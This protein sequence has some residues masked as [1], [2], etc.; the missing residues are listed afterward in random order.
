MAGLISAHLNE[1]SIECQARFAIAS[2]IL[3]LS[4]ENTINP[5]FSKE[6][7]IKIAKE[8]NLCTNNI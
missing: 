5:N 4:H 6:N 8:M 7:V 2:S 3:A 1:H